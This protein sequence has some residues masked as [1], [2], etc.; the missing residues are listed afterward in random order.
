MGR[1]GRAGNKGTAY[2]YVKPSQRELV[3]DLVKA[4]TMSKRPVPKDLRALNNE[5]KA[6]RKAG[7]KK[8]H[9]S[10]FGGKGFK[11]DED[12]AKRRR[13]T[14]KKNQRLLLLEN[15]EEVISSRRTQTTLRDPHMCCCTCIITVMSMDSHQKYILQ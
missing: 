14:E 13:E 11:F 9:S 12:E 10:G 8:Q 7:E 1:T 6:A 3:P 4:L 15:G 2:T 5:I